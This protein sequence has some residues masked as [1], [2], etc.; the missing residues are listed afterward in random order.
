MQ[1]R[2]FTHSLP[3][4]SL[5]FALIISFHRFIVKTT[6]MQKVF[7]AGGKN[8]G[9]QNTQSLQAVLAVAPLKKG[10]QLGNVRHFCVCV[11]PVQFVF[12]EL[13][14]GSNLLLGV[15]SKPKSCENSGGPD[16]WGT[17][18]IEKIETVML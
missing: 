18:R 9:R 7:A 16:P 6:Q 2:L 14:S 8:W 5:P 13:Q 3:F 12:T 1:S 10:K 4:P 15:H 11:C 17:V